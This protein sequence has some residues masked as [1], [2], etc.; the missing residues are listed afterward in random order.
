MNR[1]AWFNN[2]FLYGVFAFLAACGGGG[3]SGSDADGSTSD[4]GLESISGVVADGYLVNATVF[5]DTNGNMVLDEGEP[6]AKTSTGGQYT[7]SGENLGLYP[8]VVIV[9][10]DEGEGE[11][12]IDEDDGLPVA[13]SYQLM[14]PP[15]HHQ[16]VSPL[17][18]LIWYLMEEYDQNYET[19]ESSLL[20]IIGTSSEEVSSSDDYIALSDGVNIHAHVHTVCKTIA[21]SLGKSVENSLKIIENNEKFSSLNLDEVNSSLYLIAFKEIIKILPIVSEEIAGISDDLEISEIESLLD[22]LLEVDVDELELALLGGENFSDG[23]GFDKEFLV[24]NYYNIEWD[25]DWGEYNCT[26]EWLS[27]KASNEYVANAE[28]YYY[29]DLGGGPGL[30]AKETPDKSWYGYVWHLV[31]GSW[32]YFFDTPVVFEGESSILYEV[33]KDE[34]V[35]VS[36]VYTGESFSSSIEKI[37]LSDKTHSY[38][39]EISDSNELETLM[40]DPEMPFPSGS[41][42]YKK[43]IRL[44]SD[45]YEVPSWVDEKGNDSNILPEVE[46]VNEVVQKY[47]YEES[48]EDGSGLNI[49]SIYLYFGA[50][51]SSG[52]LYIVDYYNKILSIGDWVKKDYQDNKFIML[53]FPDEIKRE[54]LFLDDSQTVFITEIDG[55]VKWGWHSPAGT[56]IDGYIGLNLTGFNSI[57]DNLGLPNL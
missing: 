45:I 37:E 35:Y 12:T 21:I 42:A 40:V 15:G 56:I 31:D 8:I 3:G 54:K 36:N 18:T 30:W 22:G 14:S 6:S 41:Y 44:D 53:G 50:G 26:H 4:A 52:L 32:S 47:S 10:A 5:I 11:L 29:V 9:N 19:A 51:E 48:V 16:F 55:D 20:N 24:E 34:K 27:E 57:L 49:G 7:L 2:V 28:E 46:K 1:R 23:L 39:V 38:Y 25:S 13:I 43:E 17:T 33:R